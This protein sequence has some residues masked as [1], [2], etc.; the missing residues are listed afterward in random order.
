MGRSRSTARA[1]LPRKF[2]IAI[3]LPGDN[4]V[5][6]YSQDLGLLAICENFSVV[7]YNLLVGGGLG[8]TPGNSKTF[9]ALAR[10]LVFVEPEQV[11][12]RGRGDG[13]RVPRFRQSRRPAG[14][15]G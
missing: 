15:H 3:G 8:S 2:K 11:V 5:D 7:G 12:E 10:P 14:E 6:I 4:C 1:Y 9:P 13:P